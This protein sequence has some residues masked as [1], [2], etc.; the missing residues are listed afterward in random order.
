MILPHVF[1]IPPALTCCLVS[2]AIETWV[3]REM[4]SFLQEVHGVA[5]TNCHWTSK[6]GNSTNILFFWYRFLELRCSILKEMD[7]ASIMRVFNIAS[8]GS[9]CGCLKYVQIYGMWRQ[10]LSLLICPLHS[11]ALIYRNMFSWIFNV[12]HVLWLNFECL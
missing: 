2:H 9:Y 4:L 12:Q 10:I 6:P 5:K 7:I 11:R 3:A 1:D 8:T